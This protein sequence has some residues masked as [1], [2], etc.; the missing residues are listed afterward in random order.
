MS[1]ASA[2][3]IAA[4]VRQVI[5]EITSSA[6]KPA[7]APSPSTPPSAAGSFA[8]ANG[9]FGSV[10][11]AV[12]AATEAFERRPPQSGRPRAADRDR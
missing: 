10:D 5:A 1:T 7:A 2:P 12:R 4:I 11:E 6:A 8:G 3:D 9:I